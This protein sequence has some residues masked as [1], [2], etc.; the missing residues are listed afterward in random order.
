MQKLLIPNKNRKFYISLI[1]SLKEE[2]FLTWRRL[3]RG[4]N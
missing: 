3:D 1:W 4:D 2:G